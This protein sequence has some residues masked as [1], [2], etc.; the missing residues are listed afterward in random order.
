MSNYTAL[1]CLHLMAVLEKIAQVEGEQL[2]AAAPTS[3]T[4]VDTNL[5]KSIAIKRLQAIVGGSDVSPGTPGQPA[6]P[7]ELKDPW[8]PQGTPGQSRPAQDAMLKSIN[9][10]LP[11]NNDYI[12]LLKI[13]R[14]LEAYLQVALDEYKPLVAQALSTLNIITHTSSIGQAPISLSQPVDGIITH[15]VNSYG[16]AASPQAINQPMEYLNRLSTLISE[17]SAVLD[18]WV[19]Q[20]SMRE[21]EIRQQR[22]AANYIQVE[23]S[24]WRGQLP[25]VIQKLYGKAT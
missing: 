11:L 13:K 9:A 3:T 18:S 20:F 17:V 5:T 22:Q 25:S 16:G 1:D 19:S 24:S 7:G 10:P 21:S 4:P 2:P 8:K 14:W 12:D 15:V 23:L 6:R